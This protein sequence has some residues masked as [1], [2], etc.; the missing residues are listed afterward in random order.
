[1]FGEPTV[2]RHHPAAPAATA[3]TAVTA[4][5]VTAAAANW[6]GDITF[7]SASSRRPLCRCNRGNRS[8]DTPSSS[9]FV[10]VHVTA[11]AARGSPSD[12][13]FDGDQRRCDRCPASV[14]DLF[15]S[16]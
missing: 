15:S 8:S 11:A 6:V 4:D 10:S 3:V 12:V 2:H 7:R 13:F 5:A 9:V 16:S 1:L 14:L